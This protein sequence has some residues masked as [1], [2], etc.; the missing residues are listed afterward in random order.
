MNLDPLR[1]LARTPTLWVI[2]TDADIFIA[3]PH[4]LR[5]RAFRHSRL[6]ALRDLFIAR[7]LAC[8]GRHPQDAP[9]VVEVWL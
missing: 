5:A 9:S 4:G 8:V 6:D 2:H 3:R 1:P 7:G